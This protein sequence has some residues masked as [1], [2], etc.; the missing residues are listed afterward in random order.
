MP[1]H[2][3]RR[4]C[5]ASGVSALAPRGAQCGCPDPYTLT[6]TINLPTLA[7]EGARWCRLGLLAASYR[8]AQ[9]ADMVRWKSMRAP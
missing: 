8:R 7:A 9:R 3:G 6:Q 5:A 1:R 4:R 2:F